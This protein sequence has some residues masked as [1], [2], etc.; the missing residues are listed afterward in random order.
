MDAAA[1]RPRLM[2]SEKVLPVHL[3]ANPD[4]G[5]AAADAA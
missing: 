2:V 5:T 1:C 3:S 4:W